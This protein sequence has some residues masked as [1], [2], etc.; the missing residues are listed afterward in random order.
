MVVVVGETVIEAPLPTMLPPH[1]ELYHSQLA[2][3]PVDPP[4]TVSVVELPSQIVV[5]DADMEVGS[6]E[7][8]LTVTA[9]L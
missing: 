4:F 8:E 7:S 2:P 9:T 1:V 6:V 5:A 3:V